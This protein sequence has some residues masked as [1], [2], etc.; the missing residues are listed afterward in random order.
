VSIKRQ[1]I[2]HVVDGEGR[3]VR[4]EADGTRPRL[5]LAAAYAITEVRDLVHIDPQA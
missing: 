5:R 3:I 2:T 1:T 4:V